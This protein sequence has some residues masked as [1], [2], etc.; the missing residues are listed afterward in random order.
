MTVKHIV[1]AG[2]AYNGIY[3]IGA[4]KHLIEKSFFDI[5]NIKT[6]YGT[7]VGGF[8]GI[9]L[10]L[11]IEWT[12][13][14][15]YILERPWDRDLSFSADM[16]F[17]MIPKKGILD[18]SYMKIFFANLLKAKNLDEEITLKEFYEFSKIKLNL[19]AVD[20]NTFKV[21][22]ISHESHPTLKLIEAVFITCSMPFVFQPTFLNNTYLVDGGVLCNY[23]LDHCIEDGAEEDEIM[24]IQFS[25]NK[26]TRKYID[27]ST[28]IVYYG[29]Y[30]FDKLIGVA[31]KPPNNKI[32]N[33][34]IIPCDRINIP[35]AVEI[36]KK[37]EMRNS[38]I[39]KGEECAKLFLTYRSKEQCSE[40]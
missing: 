25:L 3:I 20:V 1:M 17:N 8:V 23:P 37:K 21:I 24:G 15:D 18:S 5:A 33:E 7:S 12:T 31:R 30:M 19:F 2:G 40:T 32:K 22:K 39:K 29:Y 14:I 27:E 26:D 13:I 28:N 38:Y 36:V 10:C 11:K 16:M 6:I 9:L 4:L 35:R 34:I